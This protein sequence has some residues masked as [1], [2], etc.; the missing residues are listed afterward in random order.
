MQG[1]R[2][3]AGSALLEP[4]V[5]ILLDCRL[6]DSVHLPFHLGE[7]RGRLLVTTDREYG[8]HVISPHET[9]VNISV[10]CYQ[11]APVKSRPFAISE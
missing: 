9:R 4:N 5:A 2:P 7:F 8:R 1:Y 6:F 3:G 10:L 11:K